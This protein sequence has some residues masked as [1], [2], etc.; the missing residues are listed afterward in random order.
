MV[1][2]RDYIHVVDLAYAHLKALEFL[3]EPC[4]EAIN[5]GTGNGYSVL[6]MLKAYEKASKCKV[7]YKMMPRRAGDIASCYAKPTKAKE[8]LDWEAI[9]SI[10]DMCKDT[11]AWQSKNPN[12][13]R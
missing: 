5:I 1:L 6:D 8:L 2:V 10:E 11:F 13:Y 12:G 4:C 3:K 7:P 9:Y